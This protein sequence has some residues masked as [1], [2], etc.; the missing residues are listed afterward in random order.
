MMLQCEQCGGTL[1]VG[2]QN[3]LVKCPYCGVALTYDKSGFIGRFIVKR[4]I[5][6][7]TAMRIFEARLANAGIRELAEK[8]EPELFYF[9]FWRITTRLKDEEAV[10][11]TPAANPE[12]AL[13][14]QAKLPEGEL[15]EFHPQAGY[16]AP[17]RE[18]VVDADAALVRLYS[19]GGSFEAAKE[20]AL[21]HA[22]FYLMQVRP[23]DGHWHFL[24]LE[25][26]SGK[27]YDD[28][29]ARKN[30]LLL[31]EGGISY[32][33]AF[34]LLLIEGLIIRPLI[35]K[36]F[37]FCLSMIPIYLALSYFREQEDE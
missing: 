15:T 31:F 37:A 2:P 20:L 35:G 34:F 14:S 32:F 29:P 26:S 18:V 13:F 3:L 22:P 4:L 12:V 11:F 19:Q 23:S 16:D 28:L 36:L 1:E 27:L 30:P 9:P 7:P 6:Y 17:V 25:A 8:K 10:R 24:L 21:I 5:A 33:L